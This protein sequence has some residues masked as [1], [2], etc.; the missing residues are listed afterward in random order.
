MK[1]IISI[2]KLKSQK[3][4]NEKAKEAIVKKAQEIGTRQINEYIEEVNSFIESI[5]SKETFERIVND[6]LDEQIKTFLIDEVLNLFVKPIFNGDKPMFMND[7]DYLDIRKGMYDEI[8]KRNN[9]DGS[10]DLIK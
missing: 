6:A 9:L 4:E 10:N 5:R 2:G 1:G 7:D 8:I 3:S